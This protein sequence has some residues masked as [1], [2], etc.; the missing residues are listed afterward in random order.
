MTNSFVPQA[1]TCTS[2]TRGTPLLFNASAVAH[3]ARHRQ[4]PAKGEPTL[5]SR[6]TLFDQELD[7]PDDGVI[8]VPVQILPRP[9]KDRASAPPPLRRGHFHGC[10]LPA[11]QA[12]QQLAQPQSG[13]ILAEV[14]AVWA[15]VRARRGHSGCRASGGGKCFPAAD[16]GGARTGSGRHRSVPGSAG[17]G[18]SES[19]AGANQG[20]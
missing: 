6:T 16:E 19:I 20:C 12:R 5:R 11:L 18:G 15:E 3:S 7:T 14:S 2:L 17:G 8:L 4:H 13:T 9:P 10:R 1:V